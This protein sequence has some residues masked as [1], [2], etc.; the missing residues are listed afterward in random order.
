MSTQ[1]GV[2]REFRS[3]QKQV[4]S[5]VYFNA[6]AGSAIRATRG[7]TVTHAGLLG[8]HG[9]SVMI[10]HG[11]GTESVYGQAGQVDV[12]PGQTLSAGDEIGCVGAPGRT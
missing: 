2:Q 7:G 1:F 4:A 8:G 5:G 12:H 9:Q 3:V 10:D 11:D 6:E